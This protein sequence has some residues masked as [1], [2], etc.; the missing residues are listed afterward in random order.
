MIIEI[1]AI[2]NSLYG[3]QNEESQV[4]E[5]LKSFLITSLEPVLDSISNLEN[6]WLKFI[7]HSGQY[8]LTPKYREQCSFCRYIRSNYN[9]NK[10]C[11]GSISNMFLTRRKNTPPYLGQCHAGL[12]LVAVPI[13]VA[14][15]HLG[16][17]GFGEIKKN[18][19]K[20]IILQKVSSLNLNNDKVIELFN[21]I[22]T[23]T[24]AHVL[25]IAETLYEISNSFIKMGIDFVNNNLQASTTNYLSEV[26]N[27][28]EIG[29]EYFSNKAL[30]STKDIVPVHIQRMINNAKEYIIGNFTESIYLNDVANYLHINPS[31]F[32]YIFKKATGY[33]FKNYVTNLKIKKAEEL[34]LN[35]SLIISEISREIGYKDSNYF[36][37][38]FH[39]MTG[40]SP[41]T[42]LKNQ[43]KSRFD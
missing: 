30:I 11:L 7:D 5:R 43:R 18:Y 8:V 32:S 3:G 12:T 26:I 6:I 19:N 41:S 40:V 35:S 38:V 39:K 25:K 34:L 10:R 13:E 21:E 29:I 17:L 27:N 24:D 28:S 20:A 9:G 37:R 16:Y 31:Y 42:Y 23:L 36:N 14:G 1:G 4:D 33:T 2:T 15:R 22:P